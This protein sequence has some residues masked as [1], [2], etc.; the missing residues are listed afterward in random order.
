MKNSPCPPAST[1]VSYK[2]ASEQVERI[3][4]RYFDR[5][6][7]ESWPEPLALA[8]QTSESRIALGLCLVF[9]DKLLLADTSIPVASFEWTSLVDET[10]LQRKLNFECRQS[11]IIDAQAIEHL[12]ILPMP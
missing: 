1:L 7:R 6:D 10:S 4:H 2:D 8:C 5:D 12:D 3:L 11:M 9:L